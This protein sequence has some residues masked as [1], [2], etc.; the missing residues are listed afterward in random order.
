[1]GPLSDTELTET[2]GP[3]WIPSRRFA[4]RQGKK[5]R[6]VDD[7]PMS[8]VNA[9]VGV[10]VRVS[11]AGLDTIA[12]NIKA[13]SGALRGDGTCVLSDRTVRYFKVHV[14][15]KDCNLV[16]K[17]VDLAHAY[18]Q[19]AVRRSHSSS[20]V[21]GGR[22]AEGTVDWFRQTALPYGATGSVWGF[23]RPARAPSSSASCGSVSRTTSTTS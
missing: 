16:G 17:C 1:M 21:I 11:L 12:A 13:W 20:A 8:Y 10:P 7:Y 2:L 3:L 15:F 6:V 18:R 19:V 23:N 5:L 14:D 9:T 4:V 22:S